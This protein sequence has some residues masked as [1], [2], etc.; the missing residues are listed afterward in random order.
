MPIEIKNVSNCYSKQS[1]LK[2]VSITLK[3]NKIYGLFGRNGSGKTTLFNIIS[4][5]IV[6]YDG[7]VFID[8]DNS[9]CNDEAL[10]KLFIMS[11]IMLYPEGMTIKS[12]IDFTKDFYPTFDIDYA[13]ELIDKFNLSAKKRVDK[14]STGYTSIFKLII[15]LAVNTDYV[16]YDEPVLGLDANSREI[17]YKE[18]IKNYSEKPKCIVVSSH[19]IDEIA[20][21]IETVLIIKEG[22]I[23]INQDIDILLDSGYSVTGLAS[24]VDNYTKDKNVIGYE[25]LGNYKSAYIYENNPRQISTPVLP[26]GLDIGK[27]DLQKLFVELTN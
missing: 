8:G 12:A 25:I 21:A 27:L 17:F 6:Q 15:A 4:D 18:L 10:G 3:N 14:L 13:Y 1:V 22:K 16:L 24:D 23:I 19:L 20:N 2:D 5:R 7:D 9:R 11:D 26:T